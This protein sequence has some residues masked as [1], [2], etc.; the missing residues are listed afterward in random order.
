MQT[1]LGVL[2]GWCGGVSRRWPM[3]S[4]HLRH[5]WCLLYQTAAWLPDSNFTFVFMPHSLTNNLFF[6]AECWLGIC[7]DATNALYLFH[8]TINPIHSPQRVAVTKTYI[9]RLA[10]VCSLYSA[11]PLFTAKPY[12]INTSDISHFLFLAINLSFPYSGVCSIIKV[13]LEFALDLIMY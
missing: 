7:T 3:H 9:S 8:S 10:C 6:Q 2:A 1:D 12:P 5:F 4:I 13:V 11:L